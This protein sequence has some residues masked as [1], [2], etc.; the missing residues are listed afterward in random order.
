MQEVNGKNAFTWDPEN[1]AA[2]YDLEAYKNDDLI[3]QTA[4]RVLSA[5]SLVTAYAPANLLPASATPYTW[6]VRRVDA[7]GRKGPW[8]PLQ[9]FLVTGDSPTLTSPV[10]GSHEAPN[11]TLFTWLPS[12]N[13]AKYKFEL[14]QAGSNTVFETD[15][16]PNTSWAEPKALTTGDW[17]WR[18]TAQD[19]NGNTLGSPG[20]WTD[21][22]FTVDGSVLA[23]NDVSISGNTDIGSLLTLEAPSWNVSG[24]TTTYQWQ[25]NGVTIANQTGTSYTL[26]QADVGK[27]IT[28]KAT[29]TK[30]A[31]ATGTS[32]SN[33]I[34]GTEGPAPVPSQDPSIHGT[35][36][37]G[38][39]LTAD[40][41][42][43]PGTATY[44]YQWLRNGAAI[45]GATGT[46]YHVQAAD[47]GQNLSV[48][49]TATIT[50]FAPGVATSPEVTVDK[51]VSTTT[52]TLLGTTIKKS[53]H[54]KVSVSVAGSGVSRPTGTLTVKQGKKVLAK[55]KLKASSNGRKTISLPKLGK[56][57]HKLKVV[58]SGSATVKGS[59]SK[60]VTLK[61]TS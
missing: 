26:V 38:Q 34:G 1:F 21:M 37:F 22:Q 7:A 47:G 20:D 27:T 52:A 36:K 6:R 54:G 13:A 11:D 12:T 16:T 58:Y 8:S 46:A 25:R 19:A 14:R 44:K 31:Y 41:G 24:V 51:L 40:H 53:A 60:N 55:V 49:V 50:G 15:T 9:E 39:T 29:G 56:G 57:K 30:A 48:R 2:S 59:T 28:V 3:G 10:N 45:S 5:N 35:P 32:I 42:V 61:V 43:W 4:N 33:G 23:D 18:V 17:Q